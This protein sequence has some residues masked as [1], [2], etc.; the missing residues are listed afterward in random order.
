MNQVQVPPFELKLRQ[1]GA[2]PPRN[3]TNPKKHPEKCAAGGA[4]AQFTLLAPQ[5]PHSPASW[6]ELVDISC[7]P[8]LWRM[9]HLCQVLNTYGHVHYE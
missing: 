8:Y 4:G 5:A 7:K 9:E 2:T 3:P 1:D 6:L